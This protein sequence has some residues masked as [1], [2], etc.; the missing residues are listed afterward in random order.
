MSSKHD[1]VIFSASRGHPSTVTWLWWD[2]SWGL[3][4][5][6]MSVR[7]S[8]WSQIS[9]NCVLPITYFSGTQ[10]FWTFEKGTAL[11]WPGSV[12]NFKTIGLVSRTNEISR[13]LSLRSYISQLP[14][15]PRCHIPINCQTFRILLSTIDLDHAVYLDI[16]N[17]STM[18]PFYNS[19]YQIDMPFMHGD[20]KRNTDNK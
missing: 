10:S 3:V 5:Y 7:N 6:R 14:P 17:H 12:Q 16:H 19:L 18:T 8:P 9:W 13:E 15:P 1:K 11:T 4:Q 2:R 20:S